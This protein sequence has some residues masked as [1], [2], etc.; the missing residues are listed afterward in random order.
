MMLERGLKVDHS[1][2]GR[3]VLTY[4]PQIDQRTQGCFSRKEIY[5]FSL[6]DCCLKNQINTGL[7]CLL[8]LFATQPIIFQDESNLTTVTNNLS[9]D[10]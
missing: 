9:I 7:F 10:S 4:F 2:I 6:W 3:W 8:K 1:N 5:R